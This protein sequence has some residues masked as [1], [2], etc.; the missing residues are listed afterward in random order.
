MKCCKLV[1]VCLVMTA[2]TL[3]EEDLPSDKE[4][5]LS[6]PIAGEVTIN[7]NN[8]TKR[9]DVTKVAKIGAKAG[10]RA[11][12]IVSD[13]TKKVGGDIKDNAKKVKVMAKNLGKKDVGKKAKDNTEN[14]NDKVDD[15][16]DQV[17]K[18]DKVIDKA[19][20]D[21]KKAGRTA[22]DTLEK[23]TDNAKLNA[24]KPEFMAL[25]LQV[26]EMKGPVGFDEMSKQDDLDKATGKPNYVGDF[27]SSDSVQRP[28]AED[29][30]TLTNS[31]TSTGSSTD[32][33]STTNIA[34]IAENSTD[35]ISTTVMTTTDDEVTAVPENSPQEANDGCRSSISI[36]AIFSSLVSMLFLKMFN[37]ISV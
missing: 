33:L 32:A 23:L 20:Q 2:L 1:T 27:H 8:R 18:M 36:V 15:A 34:P 28:R 37:N 21:L 10:M 4:D 9:V 26:A 3:A 5:L 17:K 31:A 24:G 7:S 16:N 13:L 11:L 30:T 14:V 6:D 12:K 29:D 22:A 19:E 25:K 35:T